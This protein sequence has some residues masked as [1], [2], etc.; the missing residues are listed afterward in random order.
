MGR[1]GGARS[2][3][4]GRKDWLLGRERLTNALPC[5]PTL[6]GSQVLPTQDRREGL[7]AFAEKRAPVFT[8]E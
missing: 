4:Q 6:S 2:Q 1:L 7:L 3:C 8:G 5:I